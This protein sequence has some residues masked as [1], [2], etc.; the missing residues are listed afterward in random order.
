M[1]VRL[2]QR[3][4]DASIIRVLMVQFAML[5]KVPS[6][7]HSKPYIGRT[8][9]TQRPVGEPVLSLHQWA[10]G[11]RHRYRQQRNARGGAHAQLQLHSS[12]RACSMLHGQQMSSSG[13]FLAWA[14]R[15]VSR[16][17][18]TA[19]ARRSATCALALPSS[20]SRLPWSL[21]RACCRLSL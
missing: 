2:E 9:V 6:R 17:R 4:D 14:A 5:R 3:I 21:M 11:R 12:M 16:R 1:K 18:S 10:S 15:Q 13:M 8:V 7:G 20:W 19:A